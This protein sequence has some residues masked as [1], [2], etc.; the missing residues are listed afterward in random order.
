M[1]YLAFA[2]LLPLAGCANGPS[3]NMCR[4]AEYQRAGYNAVIQAANLYYFTG[5]P[6]PYAVE[7]GR[8]AAVKAL[9]LL[10]ANCPKAAPPL[11]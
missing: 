2:A 3:I 10:E 11:P 4:G 5:R 1:K 9:E 6:V 7:M 8:E